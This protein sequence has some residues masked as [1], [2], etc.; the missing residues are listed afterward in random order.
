[1]VDRATAHT[2]YKNCGISLA[3]EQMRDGRWGVVATVLHATE[4]SLTPTPIPLPDETFESE[5]AA[6]EFGLQRAQEWIDR[7]TPRV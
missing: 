2:E 4:S 6:R 1:M 7:N 5:A 3:T